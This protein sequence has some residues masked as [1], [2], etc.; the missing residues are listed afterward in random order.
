MDVFEF[1]FSQRVFM[2]HWS[3]L[4]LSWEQFCGRAMQWRLLGGMFTNVTEKSEERHSR[5]ILDHPQ[6][7]NS[8]R[9]LIFC[10]DQLPDNGVFTTSFGEYLTIVLKFFD[11]QSPFSAMLSRGKHHFFFTFPFSL[12]LTLFKYE[13]AVSLIVNIY[14]SALKILI[15]LHKSFWSSFFYS[16]L[17][18]SQFI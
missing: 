9:M 17:N 12:L 13:V 4:S 15:F 14:P 1:I 3:F 10:P 6:F 5:L 8:C 11:N 2:L 16:L 18:S 7:S